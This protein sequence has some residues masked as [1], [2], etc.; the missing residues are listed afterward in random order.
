[1]NPIRY[2]SRV[3]KKKICY[4]FGKAQ[5]INEGKDKRIWNMEGLR[6]MALLQCGKKRADEEI[7]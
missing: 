2:S 1:M 3:K 6:K 7:Y 5:N 4:N